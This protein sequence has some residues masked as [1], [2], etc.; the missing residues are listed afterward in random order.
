MSAAESPADLLQLLKGLAHE[1]R[2]RLLGM[3]AHREHSVQ[4]LAAGA[5][6]TEPTASHHLAMLRK[7]GLVARRV[8]GNTH[9]YHFV[10][11]AL[12]KLAKQFFSRDG[13]ARYAEAAARRGTPEAIVANFLDGDGKLASI[14]ASRKKRYAVLAWLVRQFEEDRRYTERE[15]NEQLQRHHWDSATLRREFIGYNMMQREKGV[16]W[17]IS[18]MDWRSPDGSEP[19]V[20]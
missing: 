10:P 16:Y 1:S 12:S 20:Y 14:P 8:D 13:V 9:W 11:D 6:I 15:V 17:R 18:D 3:L 5:G 19:H 2:L 7:L 4:E